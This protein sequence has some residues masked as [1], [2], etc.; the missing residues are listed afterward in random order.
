MSKPVQHSE[1][2]RVRTEETRVFVKKRNKVIVRVCKLLKEG[3]NRFE[4]S[5]RERPYKRVKVWWTH[6]NQQV[7]RKGT[8]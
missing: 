7:Y 2:K 4:A 8:G 3:G 5:S 1:R 6:E